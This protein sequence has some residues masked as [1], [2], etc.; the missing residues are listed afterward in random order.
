M[1]VVTPA[2]LATARCGW[3]MIDAP[4]NIQ[5]R[6]A[7]QTD[8]NQIRQWLALP[9]IQQW[10]GPLATTE[11]EVMLAL[12]SDHA[13]CRVICADGEAVG[14]GHA[15]DATVWGD[16]LPEELAP[17]T[18]DIDLFIAARQFRNRGVGG[19]AVGL[20][21]EEVF[22]TTLATAVCVFPSIA[23][24]QAVRAY[25]RAGF[26]WKSVWQDPIFGPSWFMV[27]ER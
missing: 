24:E 2:R 23:N 18:W 8:W 5:L 21:S 11:A 3:L 13:I 7:E 22:A 16:E 19:K 17:G 1:Q 4:L 27:R 14:Y 6:P 10:W 15:V 12:K 20:L 26:R 25:E 9:D